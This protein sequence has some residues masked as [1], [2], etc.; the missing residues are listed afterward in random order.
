ME[1]V[2]VKEI[3]EKPWSLYLGDE[4]IGEVKSVLSLLDVRLQ[5]AKGKLKGY[6]LMDEEDKRV[7]R[8][9]HNGTLEVYPKDLFPKL[10]DMLADLL[11]NWENGRN[12]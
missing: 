7:I 10:D 3:S 8:I 2:T 4:K 5:I 6:Y 9:D 11:L 1:K 12:K